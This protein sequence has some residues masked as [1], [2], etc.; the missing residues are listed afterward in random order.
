MLCDSVG[1]IDLGRRGRELRWWK[2]LEHGAYANV[3]SK[4]SGGWAIRTFERGVE[5]ETLACGT[6]SVASA[7]LLKA[8]GLAGDETRLQTKSGRWLTVRLRDVA[9][10]T[11][12]S[13]SGEGR[14]VYRGSLE[15]A[16]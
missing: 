3:V 6:G 7:A 11:L 9:G 16:V 8:W 5:G 4:T 14:L 1:G 12:A 13:L 15:S 2:T 10:E